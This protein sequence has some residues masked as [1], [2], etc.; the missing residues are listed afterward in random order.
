MEVCTENLYVNIRAKKV[1]IWALAYLYF[2]ATEISNECFGE[3]SF[4]LFFCQKLCNNHTKGTNDYNG[5]LT[6]NRM[7]RQVIKI[8]RWVN[9]QSVSSTKLQEHCRQKM[10]T[11]KVL[12]E[13]TNQYFAKKAH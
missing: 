10:I 9:V 5:N 1:N 3:L 8:S 2:A 11:L 7:E 4:T 13:V 6:F 12:L